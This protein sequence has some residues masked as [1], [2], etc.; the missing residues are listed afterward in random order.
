MTIEEHD[1]SDLEEKYGEAV[2]RNDN[3]RLVG[4]NQ[5]FFANLF[6]LACAP[7]YDL[8]ERKFYLYNATNGL[9]E[10]QEEHQIVYQVGQMILDYGKTFRQP[11][12]ECK[13]TAKLSREIL[14]FLIALAGQKDFFSAT[15]EEIIHCQNGVLCYDHDAQGWTL[16]PFASDFRSRNRCNIIYDPKAD[17]SQFI[18]KL[19]LSAMSKEDAE[20]LQWYVGQC[21]IGRNLSQ[22]LLMLTGTAGGGK[23]TL[24]NIIEAMIGRHNCTE[25]RLEHMGSR[26]ELQ[27]LVG[28]TL[29][30]AK[31]VKSGFLD[32][33]SAYKLKSLVG[34]D[35]MTIESKGSND[36]ADIQGNFNAIITCNHNLR[37]RFD[38]DNEAWRR[39]MLWIKY[40]NPPPQEKIVDFDKKLLA[41]ESSG[42][43]NW[44]LEGAS[45]L[46]NNDGKIVRSQEQKKRVDELILESEPVHVFV[47]ECVQPE[48]GATVTGSELL[49]AFT[50]YCKSRKWQILPERTFQKLLPDV[51]LQIYNAA[52]R[53]DIKRNGKSQRGYS[54][55]QLTA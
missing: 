50:Q 48:K 21:L 24:V 3:G 6:H 47:K 18:E 11:D 20:L 34:N 52:K 28:K 54:G 43:L 33:N 35:T 38:G 16:K 41:E 30:T 32:T 4:I 49:V 19:I 51:M 53:T 10:R 23:S 42:I 26:F 2:S 13:V 37:V 45:K 27:R 29:L 46:M 17:C 12:I 1:I 5:M 40:N 31:D 15:R 44:A 9:W 39:R 7:I 25:L 14:S 22:T 55:L 36:S 8:S